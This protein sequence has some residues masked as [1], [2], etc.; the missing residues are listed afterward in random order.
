MRAFKAAIL[1]VGLLVASGVCAGD[2]PPAVEPRRVQ[3]DFKAIVQ[4]DGTV[5]DIQPDA[6]LPEA[7]QA[8]IRRRVATWRYT[9]KR[10]QG[11]ISVTPI[12]QGIVV[13]TVPIEQGRFALRIEKVIWN[14]TAS[15]SHMAPPVYPAELMR[16]GIGA[17]LVYRV[18]Y[19]EAGKPQQID[20]LYP[21]EVNRDIALLDAAV[22]KAIAEWTVAN[23]FDGAPI[24]CRIKIPMTFRPPGSDAASDPIQVPAE[25]DAAFAALP[26][27]CPTTTLE[28]RVEGTLL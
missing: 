13:L 5:A 14:G 22:R 3:L 21:H 15:S 23:T 16:R 20:L 2:P 1:S 6:S 7:I 28:T 17:H 26:D 18:V 11:R 9:P 10:W 25:V 8:M 12:S 27:K 4:A 19:D 24:S